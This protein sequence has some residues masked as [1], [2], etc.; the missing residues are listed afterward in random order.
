MPHLSSSNLMKSSTDIVSST[1]KL[2]SLNVFTQNMYIT[3]NIKNKDNKHCTIN[4]K[5]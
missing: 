5:I 1:E 3:Y 2:N 4:I